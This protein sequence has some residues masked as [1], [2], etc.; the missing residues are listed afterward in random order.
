MISP[1]DAKQKPINNTEGII[2]K[3]SNDDEMPNIHVTKSIAVPERKLLE[4]AH[5]NSHITMSSRFN[6]VFKTA[7]Q[8]R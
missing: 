5:I 3:L 1:I 6:G 8:V 2:H 7:S 4:A